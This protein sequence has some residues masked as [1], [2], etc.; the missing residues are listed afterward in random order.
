[1]TTGS[2][3]NPA[4]GRPPLRSERRRQR[5]HRHGGQRQ[6]PGPHARVH[7]EPGQNG[8]PRGTLT[9]RS[10]AITVRSVPQPG[11]STAT[12]PT[13]LTTLTTPT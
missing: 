11:S 13:T 8:R 5:E 10:C 7:I 3:A 1:M 9:S 6:S 4:S 2:S 12:E